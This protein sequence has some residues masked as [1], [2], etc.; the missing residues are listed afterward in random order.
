MTHQIKI[1]FDVTSLFAL[2]CQQQESTP[3]TLTHCSCISQPA[4]A[5]EIEKKPKVWKLGFQGAEPK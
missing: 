1:N 3:V 2:A 5:S 4:A